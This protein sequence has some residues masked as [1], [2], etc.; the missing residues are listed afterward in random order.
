MCFVWGI[1]E[2]KGAEGSGAFAPAFI[3]DES[4]DGYLEG[5]A[6]G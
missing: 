2:D 1:E 4:G 6:E 3:W 5:L